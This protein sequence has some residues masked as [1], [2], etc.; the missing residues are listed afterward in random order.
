MLF[1]VQARR[2]I[3]GTSGTQVYVT[4]G[5]TPPCRCRAL[6]EKSVYVVVVV[7]Y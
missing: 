5:D 3:K 2:S 6:S 1:V 4:G 7:I